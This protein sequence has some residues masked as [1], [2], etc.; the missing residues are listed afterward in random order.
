M[1]IFVM[2]S[3]IKKEISLAVT[4]EISD[5]THGLLA[6]KCC[7]VYN[8]TLWYL[9][10]KC[11]SL[12]SSKCLQIILPESTSQLYS[13]TSQKTPFLPSVFISLWWGNVTKLEI[14]MLV[15][16]WIS[17]FM[18]K[19]RD[20]SRRYYFWVCSAFYYII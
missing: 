8:A 17:F 2:A 12:M 10:I 18:V 6:H 13:P 20:E 5:R 4:D 3:F 14:L 1:I 11:F 19:M 15:I 7:S 16:L 9:A